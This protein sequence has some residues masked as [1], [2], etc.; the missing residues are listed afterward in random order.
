[1]FKVFKFPN[2]EFLFAKINNKFK[3]IC[4]FDYHKF[5]QSNLTN[6]K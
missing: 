4:I 2:L 6:S 5:M 1:M 3:A